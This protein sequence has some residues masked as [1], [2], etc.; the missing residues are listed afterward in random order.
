MFQR[1]LFTVKWRTA[2]SDFI[3][4]FYTSK[5]PLYANLLFKSRS[6][7]IFEKCPGSSRTS[8]WT[9]PLS[10]LSTGMGPLKNSV[11]RDREGGGWCRGCQI[12][13]LHGHVP[14]HYFQ[15]SVTPACSLWFSTFSSECS[16]VQCKRDGEDVKSVLDSPRLQKSC[17]RV[18]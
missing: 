17:H 1:L 2:N 3:F 8:F 5:C 6:A 10:I 11:T 7:P 13:N 4:G 15:S 12:W 16:M 18:Y 14:Q 9:L